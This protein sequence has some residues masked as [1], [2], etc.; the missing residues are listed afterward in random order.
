MAKLPVSTLIIVGKNDLPANNIRELIAWMKAN[1]GK[2]SIANVGSGSGAHVCT[3][4]FFD[5][6]GTSGQL[7]P[8]RGG[9][10]VMQDLI[11]N[12]IDLFCA[13][14]SQT[15]A[16]VRAGKMKAFVVLSD[17]RW[18][19]LP[20]VPTMAE[21]GVPDM[22]L[23]FWH[24][25]WAPKGTP[26]DVIDKLNAAVNDVFAKPDV[27]KRVADLGMV[28]PPR[29]QQTPAAL[30]AYHKSEIEKWWPIIKGANI[31]AN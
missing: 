13:E 15:M 10:P 12:Q 23:P 22:R 26:K 18:A 6:T 2:A 29:D 27:Q 19:P 25:L 20:D 5:K 8:Y 11:G 30:A 3:I 31:K 4:Y 28:I 14:A 7:V 9:A 1:P 17:A 16:H 24:G 21:A